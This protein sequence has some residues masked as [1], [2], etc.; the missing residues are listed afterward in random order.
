MVFSSPVFLFI[1]FPLFY[2]GYFLLP[3]RFRNSFILLS[4]ACFYVVGAGALTA[5]V[6]LL[7]LFNYLM[8]RFIYRLLQSPST[9]RRAV[10]ALTAAI[11]VNL[12]PLLFFKY[13]VFLNNAALDLFGLHLVPGI[14]TWKM[15]LPLGISFYT[16]HFI[17]YLVDVYAR[18]VVPETNL[19]RFAIY[20][21]LFPHLIA[22]PIVRFA[23]IRVQ[24]D[25]KRRVLVQK[26]MFW[27][28]VIFIIGLAK[29][30]LIAD[31]LGSIVD[32]VHSPDAVLTTYSAWLAA[33]CYSFQIY[34]DFSGY[35]DMAIGM[36]RMMGFRFPRNFNRPY[37]S[38]TITEFWQRWHM[39]LSRWFRD[40]VYIP[41]GGNRHGAAVTYRNLLIV[42]F[43]CAMWHGA[44]YTF[45]IW[46]M[47]H[48]VLLCLERAGLFKPEKLRL[49][50]LPVFLLT[51]L[52]WV[53]FRAENILQMKLY[54]SAMFTFNHHAVPLWTQA[55]RALVDPKTLV[56]L[57]I[58]AAICLVGHKP[59][60]SLRSFSFRHPRVVGAYCFVLYLL[61]C[62]SAVDR[63]FNPFIYFQF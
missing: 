16:F 36:A 3:K 23:E 33:F 6:L 41:L 19:Q 13:L 56:L 61:A 28:L 9:A 14:Q 55:D 26:D 45:L 2:S 24:L 62:I 11:A 20:I 30:I 59:F 47:G 8:G 48:G 22:G 53:P 40:Y 39:T 4:S 50:S 63:G 34:F 49:G 44:A 57:I 1:F 27:G 58:A 51:T 7:M 18:R 21:A 25:K 12:G 60:F 32:I 46:G 54:W 43:L 15:V 29:K 38:T 42:F 35:T 37:M 17:S 5:V 10:F 52:L 31:S